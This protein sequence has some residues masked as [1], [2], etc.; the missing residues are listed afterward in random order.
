MILFGDGVR[1]KSKLTL[2]AA[3]LAAL[4]LGFVIGRFQ[5]SRYL[6]AYVDLLHVSEAR[7][8]T[9]DFSRAAGLLQDIRSG[10]TN[11]A[12]KSLEDALD[13]N[14]LMIGAVVEVTPVTER[15]PQWLSRIRWLREHRA[16][17]PRRTEYPTI[18]EE[19]AHV[20][21]LIETNRP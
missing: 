16:E 15:D 12:I 4:A 11:E 3:L 9:A 2:I 14:I 5:V 21:S 18:D 10:D 7:A 1:M 13:S 20:L 19:V 17:Y 6:K 8:A